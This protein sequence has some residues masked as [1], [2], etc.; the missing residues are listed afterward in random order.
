MAGEQREADVL[1][2]SKSGERTLAV[3]RV[4]YQQGAVITFDDI[5]DQLSDQ[6]RA[7][8]SDVARRI[9]HEIK[10]P[11]TPIQLAA[12]R[13]Q[14][15]FG[16]EIASDSE[17]FERLTGTIVR[18]VGDLRRMV[19]E[20]SYFARMPKPVFRRENVHRDRAPVA[21]PA[22]GR[23]SGNQLFAPAAA[24]RLRDGL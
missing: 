17:T 5:T 14:R 23:S 9:A 16:K 4:R 15:R 6:R 19:D 21:V 2:E 10:N 1:V 3:K 8:W 11:L 12:E 18:Q 20:F 7:A 24:G 22:R 13:L